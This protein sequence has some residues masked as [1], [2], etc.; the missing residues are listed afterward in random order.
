MIGRGIARD[1]ENTDF[2]SVASTPR[3]FMCGNVFEFRE[4]EECTGSSNDVVSK[5]IYPR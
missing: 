2:V 4:C 3:H 1:Q 5:Q